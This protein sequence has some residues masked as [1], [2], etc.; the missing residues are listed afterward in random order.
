MGKIINPQVDE[1][2]RLACALHGSAAAA[3][4]Y[5][6]KS[7]QEHVD[8]VKGLL[9]AGDEHWKAET[10]DIIIHGLTLLHRA[11]VGEKCFEALM[12]QRL[13]RFKAKIEQAMEREGYGKENPGH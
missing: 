8:E 3:T 2:N 4:S 9:E 12:T 7:W 11:G 13:A 5:T 10:V 6:F 1:I